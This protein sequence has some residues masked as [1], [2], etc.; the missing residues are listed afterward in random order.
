MSNGIMK[1]KK[2]NNK[3]LVVLEKGDEIFESIYKVIEVFKINFGWVNGIG[4]AENEIASM[5]GNITSKENESFVHLHAVISD[6]ECN[7][8]AGHLFTATISVTCEMIINI[9]DTKII[10]NECKDIGLF[11]WNFNNGQRN[12]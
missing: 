11:L 6:E 5:M 4:A 12:N 10:R 8:F 3:V 7:A 2:E 9:V 1:Y